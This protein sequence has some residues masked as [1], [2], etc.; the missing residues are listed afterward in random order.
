M[1]QLKGR[2]KSRGESPGFR[3]LLERAGIEYTGL[4]L[5]DM[6]N[7]KKIMRQPMDY[8]PIFSPKSIYLGMQQ[9]WLNREAEEC[10]LWV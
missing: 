3:Q 10:Y 2:Q 6:K 5:V 1:K 9:T 8:L 7:A 4:K